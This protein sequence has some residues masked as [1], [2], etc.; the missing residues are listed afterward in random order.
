MLPVCLFACASSAGLFAQTA[1]FSGAITTLG[2]GFTG[3][4][5]VAVDG[6][7]NVFVGYY[8]GNDYDYSTV[9]EIFALGLSR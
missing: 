9:Y 5:G 6:S 1:H 4:F 7:G 8:N 3:P 2:S